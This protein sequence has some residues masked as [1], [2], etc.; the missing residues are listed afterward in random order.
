LR[1]RNGAALTDD[2]AGPCSGEAAAEAAL[3]RRLI[4]HSATAASIEPSKVHAR[5]P[6]LLSSDWQLASLIFAIAVRP[7][8]M[9]NAE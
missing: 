3:L 5:S 7:E 1:E 2:D 9:A 8:A 6:K 4:Q